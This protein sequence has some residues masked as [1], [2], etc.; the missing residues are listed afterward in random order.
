[1]DCLGQYDPTQKADPQEIL[2]LQNKDFQTN[3]DDSDC[4]AEEERRL[5]T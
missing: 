1:M 4:F 2:N 5:Y 3:V